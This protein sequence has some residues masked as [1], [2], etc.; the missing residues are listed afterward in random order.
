MGGFGRGS[1]ALIGSNLL[2]LTERGALVL[3]EA[4]TN[5]F[6]E[7]GRFQ[8]IPNYQPDFNKC[9]NTFAVSDGQVYVRSTAYA[10]RFD[11]SLPELK[12]DSPQLTANSVQLIIRTETGKA[13]DSNRLAGLELR[14]STNLGLPPALWTKL[15]NAL[16]LTNG[17]VQVTNVDAGAPRRFFIVSEPD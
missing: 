6:V 2:V 3:A 13:V 12:L 17:V 16:V 14:A 15:T 9:W 5:A 4:N 11:L 10:A 8:A 1:I 7:L